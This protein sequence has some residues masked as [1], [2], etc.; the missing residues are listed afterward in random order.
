MQQKRLESWRWLALLGVMLF[1]GCQ[2]EVFDRI[3]PTPEQRQQLYSLGGTEALGNANGAVTMVI[4]SS[5][6]CHYCREDYPVVRQF[7]ASHPDLKVI[8]KSY[9]AFGLDT[10]VDAQYAA[11]AA[12]KQHQFV[13]MNDA[14][15][16]TVKPLNQDTMEYL[17]K[18][19]KLNNKQ[20]L[21]D[22]RSQTVADQ[23]INNTTLID[24]LGIQGIPTVIMANSR[25]LDD[26]NTPQYIQVGSV[27]IDALTAMYEEV[28]T[29]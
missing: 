3:K 9:L 5:Y 15:F 1:C 23:V 12:A 11:L 6:E 24:Q 13:A 27:N 19:L 17:A 22:M 14:L 8:Y 25:V 7:I 18:R 28:K 2:S 10:Q 16:L 4:L 20:F 21:S 26:A 29:P